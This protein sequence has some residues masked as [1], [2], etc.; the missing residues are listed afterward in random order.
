MKTMTRITLPSDLPDMAQILR[1]MRLR[2]GWSPEELA[3]KASLPVKIIREYEADPARLTSLQALR[4]LEGMPFMETD[5]DLFDEPSPGFP[6]K[7][8]LWMDGEMEAKMH[9]WEAALRIDQGRF[10]DALSCLEK[11][12]RASPSAERTSRLLLSRAAV[13]SERSREVQALADLAEA[14]LCLDRRLE[15]NLWMRLRLE[16][17]H[18]V[19]QLGRF[20]EA[21]PWLSEAAELAERIGRDWERLQV[22]CIRGWVAAGLGRS[23]EAVAVFGPLRADL[24]AANRIFESV[25]IGLDLAGLLAGQGDSDGVL[26]LADEL[27]PLLGDRKI[28]D[29]AKTPLKLF[30]WAVRRGSFQAARG[31]KLSLELRK[32]GGR[33]TRP[34]ELPE[35][36]PPQDEGLE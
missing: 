21:E 26:A 11:G 25:A 18:A 19:C 28:P 31:P 3:A 5:G 16:Q 34:F 32:A 33:L 8:P 7:S 15:A 22:R 24:K 10:R 14:E 35:G 29:P 2:R 27:E 17:L 13:L 36:G 23:A 6:V 20:A 1:W 9:E 30:C 4:I 12:L